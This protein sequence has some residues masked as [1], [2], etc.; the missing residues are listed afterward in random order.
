MTALRTV[1]AYVGFILL[2]TATTTALGLLI[3]EFLRAASYLNY[4]GFYAFM[5][6][7]FGSGLVLVAKHVFRRP[8]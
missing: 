7:L 5:T 2:A 4:I 1:A 8:D 6:G 3:S